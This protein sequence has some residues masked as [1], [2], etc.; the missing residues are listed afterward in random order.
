MVKTL[1][2]VKFNLV[3]EGN[4]ERFHMNEMSDQNFFSQS[5]FRPVSCERNFKAFLNS[6]EIFFSIVL[7]FRSSFWFYFFLNNYTIFTWLLITLTVARLH[8]SGKIPP[9][10]EHVA[11]IKDIGNDH[12]SLIRQRKKL[13]FTK[14][15]RFNR[16]PRDW[17]NLFVITRI[18]MKHWESFMTSNKR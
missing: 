9:K 4:I 2:K 6:D 13:L 16:R 1:K 17:Q 10:F 5:N 11:V 7:N 3:R 14:E 8:F 15:P 18:C 12:H